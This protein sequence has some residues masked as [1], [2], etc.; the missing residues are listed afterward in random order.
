MRRGISQPGSHGGNSSHVF[1]GGERDGDAHRHGERHL[2]P[3]AKDAGR[4]ARKWI[5]IIAGGR[6]RESSVPMEVIFVFV[7][8]ES[9]ATSL[10]YH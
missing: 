7:L 2:P 3:I 9:A 10:F 1:F 4:H 6:G 5:K 8:R